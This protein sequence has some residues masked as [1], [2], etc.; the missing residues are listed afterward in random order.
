MAKQPQPQTLLHAQKDQPQSLLY[1]HTPTNQRTTEKSPAPPRNPQEAP[2]SM[3]YITPNQ[4][5]LGNPQLC[6]EIP[7]NS[8][9][10]ELN[11]P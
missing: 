9:L 2:Y 11:N 10:Y 1:C 4:E 8:L 7:K 3:N 5:A 6:R